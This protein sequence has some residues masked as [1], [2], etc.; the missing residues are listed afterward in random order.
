MKLISSLLLLICLFSYQAIAQFTVVSPDNKVEAKVNIG[1][2]ISYSVLFNGKTVLIDSPIGFTFKNSPPLGDDMKLVESIYSEINETWKPILK[3]E[4]EVLNHCNQLQL[5]IAEIR[6]PN[7]KINLTFR[8]YNDGIAFRTEFLGIQKAHQFTI[9][10]EKTSFYFPDDLTCWA[11]NHKGYGSH[12]ENEYF[13]HK[14]SELE[15]EWVIG[16]PMT[17]KVD[18]ECYV[19][20]TEADLTNFAGMY[21]KPAVGK[22]KIGVK[23]QLAPLPGEKEDGDKVILELP[24]KTPWRVVMIGETPGRLVESEIISNLNE[25]CAIKDPSWIKPG[26]SAWDHWWSGRVKMDTK[27]IKEYIDLASE[28]GWP[29]QLI[30]WQWYGQYNLP[31]ADITRVTDSVDMPEVLEY[32]KKK[33]VR[34]WLWL[35]WAD[36]D[37]SDF[38]KACALYEKWGIAGVKIDFMARDDQKMVNW[39]HKIAKIAAQ[40]HLMV[41]FHGAYKPTGFQR[42]YPNLMTQ[43]GVLGNEYN[44][45]SMR[46]TPEHCVTLPFTRMLAGPMDFTPGGFI[47]RNGETF[48]NE[49]PSNV[50]GTRCFQLAQFVIYDSPFQVACDHPV[51][52]RGQ[53]GIEFLKKVKTVWDDTKVLNGQIGQFITMARRSADDWF[54]GSMTNSYARDLEIS[55]DFLE[56]GKYKMVSFADAP[57]SGIDATKLVKSEIIVKKGDKIKIKMAPGGGFAA[58]LECIK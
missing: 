47:N 56:P 14:L 13:E 7:R 23:T 21:L 17:V 8:A 15:M 33:N 32:A 6:F 31:D 52:Y 5:Q 11:A 18:D 22:N 58:Y 10:N 26:I 44:K 50:M 53:P 35:Y 45:W 12:Q 34:C 37:R 1:E 49:L 20:I 54:I 29:Y 57:D 24:H 3:R 28:M 19:A 40:H 25:P 39:Y 41:D 38:E 2:T 48:A 4:T 36:V 51:N 42:T 9:V 30:D 55:L 16:L 27:T 43:E 46:V